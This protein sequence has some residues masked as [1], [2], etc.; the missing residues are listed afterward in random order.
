[1]AKSI[2]LV[3]KVF[4]VQIHLLNFYL[5]NIHTSQVL[6][7]QNM[8]FMPRCLSQ[9]LSSILFIHKE[10]AQASF[11]RSFLCLHSLQSYSLSAPF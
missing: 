8:H 3:Y 4:H 11:P 7:K 6:L 5:I 9:N 1:M 10:P 2:S